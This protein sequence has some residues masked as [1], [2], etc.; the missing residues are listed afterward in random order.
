LYSASQNGLKV[1]LC[2]YFSL[3]ALFIIFIDVLVSFNA[4]FE[5]MIVKSYGLYVPYCY[6]YFNFC[7]FCNV[8]WYGLFIPLYFIW[9]LC[10]GP[11]LCP[12]VVMVFTV[13]IY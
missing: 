3:C 5:F 10:K 12:V 1:A 2:H 4:P 11:F 9:A 13:Y 7:L 6:Y 8:F